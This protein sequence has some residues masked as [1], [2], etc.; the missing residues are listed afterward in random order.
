MPMFQQNW[1]LLGFFLGGAGVCV[2]IFSLMHE[3]VFKFLIDKVV[4]S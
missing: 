2:C 4:V 3:E 1:N